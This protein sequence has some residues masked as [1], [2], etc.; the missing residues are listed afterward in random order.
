[1]T[2]STY[3]S[4][5]LLLLS[6]TQVYAQAQTDAP[7]GERSLCCLAWNGR[8]L[9]QIC[10]IVLRPYISLSGPGI[11]AV[12]GAVIG[13]VVLLSFLLGAYLVSFP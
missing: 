6:A 5:I 8:S 1:M 12:V 10:V 9:L 7:S 11:V 4:G 13:T 2:D 3:S